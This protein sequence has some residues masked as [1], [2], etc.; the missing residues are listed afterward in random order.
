MLPM[1]FWY[2]IVPLAFLFTAL[3]IV[4]SVARM[5]ET[6]KKAYVVTIFFELLCSFLRA[7]LSFPLIAAVLTPLWILFGVV[8][9]VGGVAMGIKNDNI[10]S[11]ASGASIIGGI[12]FTVGMAIVTTLAIVV[13]WG[14][15]VSSFL[16]LTGLRGGKRAKPTGIEA[17]DE[18][19]REK[20]RRV[21]ELINIQTRTNVTLK[22]PAAVRVI[23]SPLVR[24]WVIGSTLY[25]TQGALKSPDFPALLAHLLYFLN[26]PDGRI[27]LSIRRLLVRPAYWISKGMFFLAPGNPISVIKETGEGRPGGLIVWMLT[28]F[29]ALAGGGLGLII[30]RLMWRKHWTQAIY[31][32]DMYAARLGYAQQLITYLEKHEWVDLFEIAV[33][34]PALPPNFVELRIDRLITFQKQNGIKTGTQPLQPQ[35]APVHQPVVN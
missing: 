7:G 23:H 22:V 27:I 15:V 24:G 14:P 13:G 3:L 6:A 4:S 16:S 8:S 10:L 5:A 32:A 12:L 30:T 28:G 34:Y 2:C 25:L 18:S 17:R 29:M 19:D 11:F 21:N 33:P 31:R 20:V 9:L 1:L 35:V 26:C